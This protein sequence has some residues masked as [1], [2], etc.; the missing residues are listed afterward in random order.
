MAATRVQL[1][2]PLR[3]ELAG[4]DVALPGRQ[5]RLAFAYLV[6]NRHGPLSR[7]A[8]IDVLW[9]ADPPADPGEALSALLSHVRRAVGADVLP[10]RQLRLA[11]PPDTWVD[12]EAAVSTAEAA[13]HALARGDRA[14]AASAAEACLELTAAGFLTGDDAPWLQERRRDVDALRVR[15]L[16]AAAAAGGVRQARAL[17]EAVPFSESAHGRLMA[18]LAERGDA[19]EALR[20]YDGLRVRL[21]DELGTAP[22]PALQA[23]HQ[24]LLALGDPEP[25]AAEERKLVTVLCAEL[26]CRADDPEELRT[27]LAEAQRQV[28][29]VV[30]GLGGTAH[31]D[32]GGTVTAV[33]GAPT[34]HE[35][36]PERAAVAALELRQLGVA[37]RV[38][39][40]SGEA[41]VD[42]ATATG[43]VLT[44]AAQ[45]QRAGGPGAVLADDA[46]FRATRQTLRYATGTDGRRALVGRQ[47][48]GPP[49][50]RTRFVG[51]ARELAQ[52][53]RLRAA[54]QADGRPRLVTIAGEAGVGKTRLVDEVF[55]AGA[56][57]GRCLPY[58]EGIT[59]WA[60]REVLWQAAGVEPDD[61]AAAV[62]AK[63]ARLAPG[64]DRMIA[65]LA[66]TAGIAAEPL[67]QMSPEA[68]ADEIALA[69][70]RLLATLA[71]VVLIVEDLHWA[72]PPLLALL[73]AMRTRTRGPVLIV[74]TARPELEAT[75][76]RWERLALDPLTAAQTRELAGA[77]LPEAT[78]RIA[79]LAEGNPFFAEELARHLRED[80]NAESIPPTVRSLLAA[81]ID[82][83][84]A[85]EKRVLQHAAVV[86]RRFWPAALGGLAC[87][88]PAP[89]TLRSLERRGFVVTLS[90][91]ELSFAH[92]LTREVAYGSLPRAERC[93]AH[94]AVAAW[95]ERL[96][97]DRRDEFAE[98]LAHH[99]EA[100]VGPGS[101]EPEALRGRAVAALLRAGDAARARLAVDAALRFADRA[102]ALAADDAER[103]AALELRA[104]AHHAA[105]HGD[106]ALAAYLEAIELS[107]AVGD[108]A[109][110]GRLRGRAALL[111]TRYLGAFTATDVAPRAIALVEEGIAEAGEDGRTFEVGALLT[112]RAWGMYR[113]RGERRR[114]VKAAERDA[115]RAV[116]IAE[117]IG[118]PML[119]AVALEGLTWISFDSGLCG[120]G[121]LGRRHLRAAAT[122]A[123][124]VEAHE[125]L[126]VAA[127]SFAYAGQ[128]DAARDAAARATREA[129]GLSP[130]RALHAGAAETFALV[131]PGRLDALRKANQHVATH[132][133]AEGERTC[134][135]GIVGLAGLCLALHETR[136]PRA[137]ETLALLERLAP[138]ER[139][140]GGWGRSVADI[141]RPVIGVAA[142]LRR[143][144]LVVSPRM[145]MGVAV[146]LR[147]EIPACALAGEFERLTPLVRQAR[148]LAGPACA[149]A[150]DDFADW[151]EA[152]RA[153]DLAR[154][155]AACERLAARGEA[156]TAAILLADLLP[157]VG[158][159]PALVEA[160]ATRLREMG[161]RA[162]AAELMP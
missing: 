5:G 100:A 21:R 162:S 65:A 36:D 37:T 74:A 121:A 111:C 120:A 69:W 136:D 82:A 30:A 103:M 97:G 14:R 62:A 24:R 154:G 80:P 106:E 118:S 70:P 12:L 6:L 109:A 140:L 58:G 38:G 158:S 31:A 39:I 2:G 47:A 76:P 53:R 49:P 16:E 135:T 146:R 155:Q 95:L 7:E 9:P 29:E 50:R 115:R 8:L 112:A 27:N 137:A 1:C 94:A 54:V 119:Q 25:P 134:A 3:L 160:T 13:E 145:A 26:A 71:P 85:E 55:G 102:L 144:E 44:A 46:T 89:A 60:L 123:D 42:G 56:L 114:D 43:G 61:G 81:R 127:M 41:I 10:A 57:R 99:L 142:T 159:P 4:R 78:G 45:L 92:G 90:G 148:E 84:P 86:G 64:D 133:E 151:A 28:R 34:A 19:A 96:A 68:V 18:A 77:L 33:F 73:D 63:L 66:A 88:E 15:A 83:L 126:T 107:H 161:A 22:G 51:R 149:P 98:L 122:L 104:G 52:L 125:S 143:L 91:R 124:R 130:H 11:L 150:L 72:E 23:L 59:Y 153:R 87:G 101:T 152:V 132:A 67:R 156:Y 113:W 105:V 139:A 35:D 138:P 40:A 131:A 79:A 20:V 93:R 117:E 32:L 141:L 110:R 157:L 108:R 129:G 17:V 116:R 48:P 75:P 147:A 128:F